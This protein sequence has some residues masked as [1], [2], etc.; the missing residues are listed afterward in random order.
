MEW[1]KVGAVV[2]PL[3]LEEPDESGI[4]LALQAT[5]ASQVHVVY[6]LPELEPSV[7]TMSPGMRVEARKI[8]AR[9]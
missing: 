6:V 8:R 9:H 5:D 1:D 2:V 3:D 7:L 4:R